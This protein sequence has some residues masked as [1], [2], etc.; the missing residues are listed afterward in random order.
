VDSN[1]EVDDYEFICGLSNIRQSSLMEKAKILFSLYC[2]GKHK[3]MDQS[4]ALKCLK[5]IINTSQNLIQQPEIDESEIKSLVDNYFSLYDVDQTGEISELEFITLVC[6][7]HR[8]HDF[9]QRLGLWTVEDESSSTAHEEEVD[10]DLQHELN[11]KHVDADERTERIKSGI[12]HN[13][14]AEEEIFSEDKVGG[15]D[16]FMAVKPWLGAVKNSVPS[17]YK[18]TKGESDPPHAQLNLEFVHGYRCHDSR[19]NLKYAATGEIVYHTA[20]VGIVY[21]PKN[22]T[23]RFFMEHSDDIICLDVYENMAIT[24]QIGHKPLICVWD[25]RDLSCKVMLKGV[26]EKGIVNV[27]FSNDGKL[28]AASSL[29]EDH[30]I[31]VYDIE[32][33]VATKEKPNK[34]GLVAKGK[35]AKAEILD[36]RFMPDNKTLFLSCN[37]EVY[38]MEIDDSKCIIKGKKGLLGKASPEPIM[39]VGFLG[40]NVMTGLSKGNLLVWSGN[41]VTKIIDK[42]HEGAI[43]AMF[44]AKPYEKLLTGG[45]D[46]IIYSWNTKFEKMEVFKLKDNN[47]INSMM[48]KVRALSEKDGRILIGTRGSE[49]IELVGKNPTVHIR[50]HFDGELWG[51]TT[52]PSQSLYYTVGEDMMMACWDIASRSQMSN[53]KLKFAAKTLHISPDGKIIAVGCMEGTTFIINCADN[54]KMTIINTLKEKS[55]V[56]IVKFSPNGEVLAAGLA[57]PTD[58]VIIYSVKK[59]FASMA[60]LKGSPSRIIHLDFSEDSRVIQLNNSSYEILYYD[61]SNGAQS[62][63]GASQNKDEKWASW[64]LIIGWPVQGIWPPCSDGSD[65]NSVDRSKTRDVLATGDDFGKVKLFKY[66]CAKEKSNSNKYGGH[67]AHVTGVR[68]S[69]GGDYLMSTGG[70]EKSIFQWKYTCEGHEEPAHHEEAEEENS[71]K[72]K[73]GAI[74]DEFAEEEQGEGDQMGATKPYTGPLSKSIPSWYKPSKKDQLG[75]VGSLTLNYVHGYRCFDDCRN[76]AKWLAD[77]RVVFIGAALGVVFDYKKNKQEFFSKHEEDLV[78]M[79]V[80]PKGKIVATGQMAAKGKAKTIDL[81][82]WDSKTKQDFCNLN[83]FHLRAITALSF[84]SDGSK[85]LSVGQDDDNSLAIHDWSSKTLLCTSNVDKAKVTGCAWSPT[86]VNE[87]VTIGMKVIKF[88]VLSGRNVSSKIGK[89]DANDK[90]FPFTSVTYAFKG[91]VVTGSA[92]GDIATW[93]GGAAGKKIQAHK[94][95]VGSLLASGDLL[96]SGGGDGK[97]IIWE[98]KGGL[99]QK[100]IVI[101]ASTLTQY[102]PGIRSIDI[103]ANGDMLFGT[104]GSEIFV[105]EKGAKNWNS[106]LHGHYDGEVWGCAASPKSYNFVSCGGD[107]TIRMWDVGKNKMVCGT[108]PLE[109]DLRAL[110][111]DPKGEFVV[112][113]DMKGKIMLYSPDKLELLHHLQS[114]FTPSPKKCDPWI[115]DI[116]VSPNSDVIA[117][118]AHGG[119]PNIQLMGVKDSKLGNFVNM[120][121]IELILFKVS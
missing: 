71:P 36:M 76:T 94:G 1:K 9:F 74:D 5:L 52:H 109:T 102:N 83:H 21:D 29:D 116:K 99:T 31:V 48:P 20:A 50:G 114:I 32:K 38:L 66:P 108:L 84:S 92:S 47:L 117:F 3:M 61:S 81:Y 113:A 54:K 11:L 40:K 25:I 118:G 16:Q 110:D 91:I 121:I 59:N 67:S 105:Q 69:A 104:R 96:Y 12:E 65:I 106:I 70:G 35:G 42:A 10:K 75:P 34:T 73:A 90:L 88:W 41:S 24:G 26:L 79:A 85:L 58:E 7:E 44:S 55:E 112:A 60:R 80:H 19:N 89:M 15:G 30:D 120:L 17:D 13:V 101:D 68:F 97:V 51:L 46:G 115:E 77:G 63:H 33:E 78:S 87:F 100:S 111:W 28:F 86:A 82:V 103:N 93:N 39:C 2:Q 56:S 49:I 18:P 4:M 57:P 45:N 14:S 98:S 22:R 6:K 43:N 8:I 23:Q 95:E 72:N 119:Q 27:C 107:K 37:K 53:L 64:T 62:T